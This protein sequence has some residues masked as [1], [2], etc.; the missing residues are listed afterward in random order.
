MR[1]KIGDTWYTAEANKPI[2]VEL[3]PFDKANIKNMPEDKK[4]Y[5]EFAELPEDITDELR[6]WMKI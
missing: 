6:D 5:A 3:T 4:R 1:V 2:M